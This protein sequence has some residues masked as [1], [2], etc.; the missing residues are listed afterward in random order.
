MSEVRQYQDLSNGMFRS[1]TPTWTIKLQSKTAS[2]V[3]SNSQVTS[4]LVELSW[5]SLFGYV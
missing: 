2:P 5:T 3:M 1:T 4:H